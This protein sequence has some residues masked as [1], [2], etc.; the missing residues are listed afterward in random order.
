MDPYLKTENKIWW[1]LHLHAKSGFDCHLQ[2]SSDHCMGFLVLSQTSLKNVE[3]DSH[4][5]AGELK[6]KLLQKFFCGGLHKD[7]LAEDSKKRP[8]SSRCVTM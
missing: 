3:S 1:N 5:I 8:I 2:K 4:E 7:E 6:T